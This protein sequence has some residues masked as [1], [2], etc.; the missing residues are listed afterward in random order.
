M[1]ILMNIRKFLRLDKAVLDFD[2]TLVDA[3]GLLIVE[4]KDFMQIQHSCLVSLHDMS[5]ATH[6]A[7]Y[8]DHSSGDLHLSN[9]LHIG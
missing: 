8:P 3:T 7:S 5:S 1:P 6:G 9:P 4:K 2:S